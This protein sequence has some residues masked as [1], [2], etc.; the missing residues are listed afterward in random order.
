[1]HVSVMSRDASVPAC[2]GCGSGRL[3]P[4]RRYRT[5]TEQGRRVFGKGVIHL[6]ADCGLAQLDPLPEPS[7]LTEYYE[8]DYRQ[9]GLYGSDINDAA[10]FPR[11]NLFYYNR[12]RSIA[13][14]VAGHV[15]AEPKDILDVG[16]GF[17][18]VLHALGERFSSA[19]RL[20]I[21]FSDVCREHLEA[22][23]AETVARPMEAVLPTLDR[24]FDIIVLSHVLEHLLG[25]R[26][27]IDLLMSRLAPGGV[28]YIEV[29]NIPRD[30]LR[31]HLDHVW[32][33]RWDEPHIT[34]FSAESLQSVLASAGLHVALCETAGPLYRRVSAL[35]YRLPPFRQTVQRMLPRSLFHFLRGLEATQ[36]IRVHEREEEFYQ[37]GGVR[38]WIRSVSTPRQ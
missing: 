24:M 21:E 35:R 33:P 12:G 15:R 38:I 4:I 17:G 6:C 36:A 27:A 5:N 11:D 34:F 2:L 26:A 19:R 9:Q 29:P 8:H 20:A 14:L 31:T 7:S 30:S 37:Y 16:A 3:E 1:M 22:I 25:P 13:E 28:L 18:H 32:A 23:G 10:R